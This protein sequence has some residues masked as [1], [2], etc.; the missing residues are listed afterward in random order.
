MVVYNIPNRDC[1]G[2]STGGLPNHTAYRQ[3]ID[4]VAAGLQGPGRRHRARARR[5]GADD[6]LPER[7]AAGRGLRLD[8]VRRQGAQGRPRRRPRSTSTPA[9]SA[10]LAPAEMAARLVRADIANSADGISVNVSNYRTNA[11]SIP[12]VRN[13][14]AA[15]GAARPQGRHRHQPQRQR[16]GR[17]RV[18]RPGRPGDRRAQHQR[19]RRPDPGRV[20]V[21]QA[22]RR[23]GRLHRRRRPVRAAAGVRPGDRGRPGD[24]AADHRR[25]RP[26]PRRRPTTAAHAPPPTTPP[27]TPP[28]RRRGLRGDLHGRTSGR[29]AS[30]RTSGSPTTARR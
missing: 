26:R 25:R 4:Q 15:T 12:Y 23:G 18:V 11:E 30:P 29:P 13:V 1:S 22:A 7:G 17:Q 2:A 9:H 24:H 5:A 3:W 27:T 6:Q 20:P 28:R 14:I 10:W 16:A 21:D 8:G 19:G